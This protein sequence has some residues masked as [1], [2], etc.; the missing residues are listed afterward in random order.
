MKREYLAAYVITLM[1]G[2]LGGVCLPKA[3][4]QKPAPTIAGVHAGAHVQP[5]LLAD[6]R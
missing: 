2:I 3:W 6:R 4:Y 1:L 5:A